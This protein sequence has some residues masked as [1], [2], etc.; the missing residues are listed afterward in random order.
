MIDPYRELADMPDEEPEPPVKKKPAE[1]SKIKK[2]AFIMF[3]G[4][5]RIVGFLIGMAVGLTLLTLASAVIGYA[6][7]FVFF[8]DYHRTFS[9]CAI[10]GAMVSIFSVVLCKWIYAIGENN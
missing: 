9:E 2:E 10:L 6:L 7:L 5:Y 3:R 4:V 1:P 8:H